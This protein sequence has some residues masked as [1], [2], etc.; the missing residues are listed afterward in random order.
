MKNSEICSTEFLSK[1]QFVNAPFIIIIPLFAVHNFKS[2]CKLKA[3]RKFT[4][5]LQ[6]KEKWIIGRVGVKETMINGG[7]AYK[8]WRVAIGP[9]HFLAYLRFI[10]LKQT[11]HSCIIFFFFLLHCST[12]GNKEIAAEICRQF[13]YSCLA[14]VVMQR[15]RLKLAI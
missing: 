6:A 5:S 10:I 14:K 3:V 15:I 11:F 7:R 4:A 13:H 1:L 9:P 8:I 12:L 2:F